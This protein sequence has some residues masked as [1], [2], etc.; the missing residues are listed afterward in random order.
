MAS[1]PHKEHILGE[2]SFYQQQNQIG[3]GHFYDDRTSYEDYWV[4]YIANII[5][6]GEKDDTLSSKKL[7]K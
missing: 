2:S 5:E 3:V 4:V 6:A 7:I 1:K